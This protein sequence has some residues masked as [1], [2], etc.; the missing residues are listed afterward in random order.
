MLFDTH[1]HYDD[2]RFDEDRDA[3][4][5]SMPEN[6][7]G[8]IL[9]PGCDAETSR[10]AVS[11]ANRYPFVYAAVGLHPENIEDG[12]TQALDEIRTLAQSEPRVFVP[13][14][15]S[16]WIITGRRKSVRAHGS[17]LFSLVRWS[18]RAS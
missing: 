12:W 5:A 18:W 6:N 11:Y 3:L 13:S 15:R 7:V 8:L 1:A 17:R 10:K 14:E 16:V 9:N 4:L 2:E